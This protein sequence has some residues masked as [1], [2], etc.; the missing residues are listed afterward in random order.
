MKNRVV[1]SGRSFSCDFPV[2]ERTDPKLT[3]QMRVLFFPIGQSA[4]CKY[5][6][7][8]LQLYLAVCTIIVATV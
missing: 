4:L 8:H 5:G 6:T 2:G 7:I 1:D 3:V